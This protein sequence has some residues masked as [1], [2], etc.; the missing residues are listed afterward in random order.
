MKQVIFNVG[1]ALSVYTE[2]GGKSLLIDLGKSKEFH[3]VTDFLL[4]LYSKRKTRRSPKDQSKYHIDQLIVSHPHNDHFSGI[5]EFNDHFYPELLTCPNDNSRMK[6][7]E[8]VNWSEFEDSDNLKILRQML[9]NRQ[10]PLR[11]TDDQN[12][13]IYYLPPKEVEQ[14]EELSKESYCNNISISVFLIVHDHRVFLPGDLQ[15]QG[16]IELI[17]RHHFLRNKL[18]GGVDVLVT[19][20]HGL[21]S[22][23]SPYLFEQMNNNR[24]RCLNVVS[25]KPSGDVSRVIDTRYAS[26][27]FCRGVN[28]LGSSTN[29]C[30]QVKT[31]RGHLYIDYSPAEMPSFELIT[32]NN[33]LLSRF[34]E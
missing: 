26:R 29:P 12:E 31:S 3:P 34:L 2:F 23:F 20:H 27:E 4:P 25:E 28:N 18:K 5:A 19:P 16:M 24:T 17:N 6:A 15:K 8:H 11:A 21:Q 14:S 13:F 1:G 10:P 22:S 32:D 9:V 33:N 7:N 30:M